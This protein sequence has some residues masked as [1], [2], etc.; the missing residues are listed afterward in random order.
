MTDAWRIAANNFVD[1]DGSLP[2][3]E[4]ERLTQQSVS[5]LFQFFAKNGRCVTQSPTVWDN[6]QQLN[7]PLF[8]LDDPCRSLHEGRIEVFHCCFGGITFERTEIPVLG[9]FVFQECIA[10]DF[11]MGKDWNPA[12]VDAFFKL[13]AHLKTLAP[14]SH[15][16]SAESEGLMDEKSF[17]EALRPYINQAESK[18]SS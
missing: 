9:I 13:L 12:N 14:E 4:F 16:Q 5:K 11:R 15:I 17:L 7:V 1:D 3:V 6:E 2:S 18:R 10:I 8:S